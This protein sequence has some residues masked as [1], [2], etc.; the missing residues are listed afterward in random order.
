M[1]IRFESS[2]GATICS[3]I[4]NLRV[5]PAVVDQT[6]RF[7]H[8]ELSY[9][10]KI[11]RVPIAGSTPPPIA[12][13]KAYGA[14][15][16]RLWTRVSDPTVM[17]DSGTGYLGGPVD[18]LVKVGLGSSPEVREFLIA[19][20]ME[21]FQLKAAYV[22]KWVVHAL[23]R[24]DAVAT[25]GQPTAALSLL[26]HADGLLP[27]GGPRS[28]SVHTDSP[29]EVLLG[30]DLSISHDKPQRTGELN[31][32]L[33]AAT[34][35]EI[36]VR[37]QP[38]KVGSQK[39]RIN[40]V[41]NVADVVMRA[42]ILCV[43]VRPPEVTKSFSIKLPLVNAQNAEEKCHKRIAYTNSQPLAKK[44]HLHTDRP[45]LLR[46]KETEHLVDAGATV[47]LGLRFIPQA[48][49]GEQ[50]IYVFIKD[51]KNVVLETFAIETQ[52]E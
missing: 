46:F 11:M 41:D 2:T 42:W 48:S 18:V 23:R 47:Q 24:V 22:W 5:Y 1:Q 13:M 19:V 31:L 37:L 34:V 49:P 39:Y 16:I 44:L 32:V 52:Y 8:P 20:Y 50:Q 26:L 10:K 40:A 14:E 17:I 36:K 35:C 45:D 4:I 30:T 51:E 38:R 43:D 7:F 3:L 33:S 27:V 21:P 29:S 15:P 6:F 9:L 25:L 12:G 28:V